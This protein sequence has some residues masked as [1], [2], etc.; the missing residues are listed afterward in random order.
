[1]RNFSFILLGFLIHSV[2]IAQVTI[3]GPSYMCS[4]SDTFTASSWSTNYNWGVSNNLSVLSQTTNSIT[5]TV[6]GSAAGWVAIYDGNSPGPFVSKA[7]WI[8]GPAII[9]SGP[10]SVDVGQPGSSPGNAY[11]LSPVNNYSGPTIL[12]YE[13]MFWGQGDLFDY[14]N[15]ANVYFYP[16]GSARIE[17]RARNVCGWGPWAVIYV[18]ASRL[19]P[20]P[21]YNVYPNPVRDILYIEPQ[22]IISNSNNKLR[23][24]IRLYD[25]QG[26]LSLN[27][28]T[29]QTGTI[30]IDVSNLRNGTYMLQI[31]DG[32]D[33]QPYAQIVIKQ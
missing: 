21:S 9:I 33:P 32:V 10:T 5:V 13:W 22:Q 1:M 11:Y 12:E 14:G 27:T 23:Y 4:G 20:T 31:I 28:V 2:L 18:N 30:Q 15:W 3:T 6:N 17:A 24:D 26:N 19:T 16:A 25:T 8:G 29:T 7:V